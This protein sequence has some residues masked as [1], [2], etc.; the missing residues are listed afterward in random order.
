MNKKQILSVAAGMVMLTACSEYDPGLTG[1]W[2]GDYTPADLQLMEKYTENF[3]ARYGK[4]DENHTWGFGSAEAGAKTRAANSDANQWAD[5]DHGGWIVPPPLTDDQIAV[6]KKYFQTHKNPKY[7]NPN[8]TNYFVQQVYTGGSDPMEGYSPEKYLTA[9][10]QNYMSGTQLD[11][12]IAIDGEFVD[13]I[14]NFNCGNYG[15]GQ[16][17]DM[18]L[19]SGKTVNN[20]TYHSDMIMLMENSTTKSFG[21]ANSNGSVV[22]TEYT[23]LVNFQTIIDVMGDEAKC[24]KDGWNRSFMG[25]DFENVIGDDMYVPGDENWKW[26]WSYSYVSDD[27]GQGGQAKVDWPTGWAD[28]KEYPTFNV[29]SK[30]CRILSESRN[31]YA[32]DT[33]EP[34]YHGKVTVNLYDNDKDQS[35]LIGEL[36][37]L[38]YMPV[39]NSNE[40]IKPGSVADGYYSDWIVSLT[41]AKNPNTPDDSN[42]S[43]DPDRTWYRIMCE[44]LGNTNDFDF[45]DLVFDVYF[46][47]NKDN[48]EYPYIANVEV[49]AAGGTLPIY[50]MYNENKAYEAHQLLGCNST[51]TPVN[52]GTGNDGYTAKE[53]EI[54]MKTQDAD[55]IKIYVEKTNQDENLAKTTIELPRAGSIVSKAPQKICIP[56]GKNVC[57][58]R[59]M[60]Q[61][62]WGY[63]NF[64]KWVEDQDY[65]F[66]WTTELDDSR[67]RYTK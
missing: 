56:N 29:G 55:D 24:L 51:S 64:A 49:K 15:N 32:C 11:H 8:W 10:E 7:E 9:D 3:E 54:P 53:I 28:G 66:K 46:T 45:N 52:V 43:D 12:L 62:E 23:G 25:F 1:G 22:R 42:S 27:N 30:S 17:N 34:N 60:Q 14:K 65:G 13:H 21:Y 18:V 5:P 57:W 4:I 58:M 59:E 40:W 35:G 61:I 33:N 41:E 20:A 39:Q 2:A 48:S 38:G 63:P 50:L 67:G 37:D 26:H 47:E 6:V 19:D 36:M 31:R 16:A 44:D